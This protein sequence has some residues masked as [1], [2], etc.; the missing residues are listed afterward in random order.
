MAAGHRALVSFGMAAIVVG[1]LTTFRGPATATAASDPIGFGTPTVMDPVHTYGEPNIGINPAD[2]SM[3]D[4][5]PQGTGVQRSGWEGSVDG[6]STF[7]IVGQCPAASLTT[8]VSTQSC[9]LSLPPNAAASQYSVETAPGGGDAEQ[10]FD[11]NGNQYFADLYGLACQRVAETSNDGATAPESPLGCGNTAPTCA[12]TPTAPTACPGEGSDRQ[13]LSV[14]DPGFLPGRP[15]VTPHP[16]SRARVTRT[17]RG[18]TRS[19]TW[20]T[21]TSTPS[22]P[23]ARRG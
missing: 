15:T 2:G 18:R 4:S 19:C 17:T 16:A 14:L 6:G 8:T 21:T 23:T 22:R 13:W 10:K 5:G 1:S 3:Y 12:G 9:P 11:H 20:N 7:R